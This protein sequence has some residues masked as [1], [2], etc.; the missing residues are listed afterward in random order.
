MLANLPPPA[1]YSDWKQRLIL[2]PNSNIDLFSL[3]TDTT[4]ER[5]G[6]DGVVL[7][8]G[9]VAGSC[10]YPALQVSTLDCAFVS[11]AMHDVE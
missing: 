4:Q 3:N 7:G 1:P 9:G 11:T 8:R 10:C 2:V 5:L 6:I